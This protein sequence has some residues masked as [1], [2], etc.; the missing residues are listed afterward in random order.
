MAVMMVA[1]RG[2]VVWVRPGAAFHRRRP[3]DERLL[4]DVGRQA[5]EEAKRAR[6]GDTCGGDVSMFQNFKAQLVAARCGTVS[7]GL[8]AV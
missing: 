8:L 2:R 7:H 3:E 4:E 5:L 1:A 6:L